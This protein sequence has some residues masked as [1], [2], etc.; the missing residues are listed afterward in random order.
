MDRRQSLRM[1]IVNKH[2]D[3]QRRND[4]ANCDL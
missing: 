4:V 2:A 1:L 3:K